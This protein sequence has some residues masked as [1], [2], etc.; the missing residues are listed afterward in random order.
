[1][2]TSEWHDR[3]ALDIKPQARPSQS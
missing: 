1:M 2:G 3:D